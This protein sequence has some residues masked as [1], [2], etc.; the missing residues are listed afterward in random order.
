MGRT[1]SRNGRTHV[2]PRGQALVETALVMP[3]ILLVLVGIM[4]FGRA[5]NIH[6]V[7]TDAAR[8]GARKAAIWHKSGSAR[9]SAIAVV[10]RSLTAGSINPATATIDVQGDNPGSEEATVRVEVDY[11][12]ILLGPVMALA[13]QSWSNGTVTLKSSAIMRNE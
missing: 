8:Q 9:D 2:R 1:L 13:G 11:P 6:Q 4:E 12:F 3:L 7:V 10:G 5:W